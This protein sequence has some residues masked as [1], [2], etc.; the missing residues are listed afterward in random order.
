MREDIY[1]NLPARVGINTNM[2][3]TLSGMARYLGISEK[4]ARQVAK[5]LPSVRVG[6]RVRYPIDAVNSFAKPA[7]IIPAGP[8]RRV[9][10]EPPVNQ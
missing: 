1:M 8:F 3:L 10:P 2:L 9:M 7:T 5:D 6:K 4:T